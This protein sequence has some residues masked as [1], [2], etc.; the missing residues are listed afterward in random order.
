MK[1]ATSTGL[2][3]IKKSWLFPGR[4]PTTG[5]QRHSPCAKFSNLA[6][7]GSVLLEFTLDVFGFSFP[8]KKYDAF[9]KSSH[10]F[11]VEQLKDKFCSCH[12]LRVAFGAAPR[13]KKQKTVQFLSAL[14][15]V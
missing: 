7:K 1:R 11:S 12:L 15:V 9:M 14:L 3:K 5:R 8:N 4:V 6:Q 13:L 2:N 10:I